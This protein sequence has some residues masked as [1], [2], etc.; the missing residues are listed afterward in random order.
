M[1]KIKLLC[2]TFCVAVITGFFMICGFSDDKYVGEQS[3][4]TTYLTEFNLASQAL[5]RDAESY[6]LNRITI[7]SLKSSLLNTRL[8]YKK[9]E[10]YIAYH[11]PGYAN[12]HLNGAPLLHVVRG[13]S[14]TIGP[15]EGLQILDELIFSD[16]A[17]SEKV[18]I[19][20]LASKLKTAY[21]ILFLSLNK[22]RPSER[23]N[24]AAIRMQLVRIFTL[25][26]TGFDTPGSQNA[27]REASASLEAIREILI[28]SEKLQH[29][30]EMV[31]LLN[32]SIHQLTI[33][34]FDNFDRLAF[35]TGTIDPLYKQLGNLQTDFDLE[36]SGSNT[37]WNPRS[38]SIFAEDFL[39]PYAFT[40]LTK[41][42]DNDQLRS[43]G[44]LLFNDPI[45]SS[46]NKMSCVTCHQ[47]NKA[48]A[49]ASI[50]SISNVQGKTVLRN[51][52]TLLNAV[53]ADRYF[54]DL[55]AFTL[56]QQVEHVIFNSDEF[57]TD[58]KKLLKKLEA[59]LEY[60][61]RF[62]KVFGDS[63]VTRDNFTSALASYVLSLR[64]F[65]SAF[66][67]YVRAEFKTLNQQVKDGFNLFTG[68][69]NCATCHFAPTFSGLVPPLYIESESEILGVLE[70]P[71]ATPTRLDADQGRL[72]NRIVSE[73]AWIFERSFKTTS[74]RNAELTAPYFHNGA[75]AT[76]EQVID[77]YNKGGG[78]GMG[79]DVVNQTLSPD[80]LN[81]SA[82]EK[83]N[84]VAFIRSL[85]D[86]SAGNKR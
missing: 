66:D 39:N 40:D 5:D 75:Y 80:P 56:E 6:K 13:T 61:V 82:K 11:Y 47:P 48:F 10:F 85:S 23:Y 73:N 25:G 18:R 22:N 27:L 59:N 46:D 52:P 44:K 20:A 4:L 67:K 60:R 17:A 86:V 69:A 29:L 64:S 54:Y 68:K 7:D 19:S 12:E 43:L 3:L 76:L 2:F 8:S 34:T 70:N 49:D 15:P 62:Q 77:F 58:Y 30:D 21:G 33:G 38:E 78:E 71:D 79:H 51:S 65:N 84:L 28:R 42:E 14:A 63:K 72:S 1:F 24:I 50:K 45:L 35:L 9:I 74:I 37:A 81:L 41:E 55:R 53:Y 83:D 26:V 31:S 32:I 57:A 36:D 16:E